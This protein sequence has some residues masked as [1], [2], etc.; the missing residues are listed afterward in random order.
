MNA[1]RLNPLKREWPKFMKSVKF[2]TERNTARLIV[3]LKK[4]RVRVFFDSFSVH[5]VAN[6]TSYGKSVWMDK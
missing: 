6:D 4:T 3:C 2:I 1:S 5:F